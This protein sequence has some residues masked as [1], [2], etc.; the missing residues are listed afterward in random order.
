MAAQG[1]E[2][3][4]PDGVGQG[5]RINIATGAKPRI[6]FSHMGDKRLEEGNP[7]CV[8]AHQG[9]V[10]GIAPK[11]T[12]GDLIK[13]IGSEGFPNEIVAR[14]PGPVLQDRVKQMRKNP[15]VLLIL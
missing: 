13:K 14:D 9:E 15:L 1:V 12:G 5:Y 7:A 3:V 2:R 8:F 11:G 4:V 10:Y 6:G